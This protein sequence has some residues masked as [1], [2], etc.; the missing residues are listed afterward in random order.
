MEV[1]KPKLTMAALLVCV[2]SLAGAAGIQF[3]QLSLQE[4]VGQAAAQN[5]L[6]FVDVYTTWCGPCKYLSKEVFTDKGV[7]EQFNSDFISI[8]IDAERG[9]GPEVMRQFGV[10]AF[11]TLLWINADGSLAQKKVG[12]AD[13]E[14]LQHWGRTA[15]HPEESLLYQLKQQLKE[16][17]NDKLVMAQLMEVQALEQLDPTELANEYVAQFPALDLTDNSDFTAFRFAEKS[18]KSASAQQF[19]LEAATMLSLHESAALEAWIDILE[20]EVRNAVHIEDRPAMT[21]IA[22]EMY[23]SYT[24]LFQ[25]DALSKAELVA[26]LQEAYDS[27]K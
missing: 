27:A 22:D 6:V 16:K 25:E 19:M 4:A 12:A 15:A 2:A 17:P 21:R 5:K 8:K 18:M 11:P 1:S 9:E 26:A 24:T 20:T 14:T 10:D 7:G 13:A 23:P 3:E